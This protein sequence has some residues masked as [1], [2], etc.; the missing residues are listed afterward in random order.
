MPLRNLQGITTGAEAVTGK[1]RSARVTRS[2]VS[3]QEEM[4]SRIAFCLVSWSVVYFQNQELS[5]AMLS[6]VMMCEN[7]CVLP[8][9]VFV[10]MCGCLRE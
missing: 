8:V 10:A 7:D 1:H 5:V 4:F 3:M 9:Q 6:C 2:N